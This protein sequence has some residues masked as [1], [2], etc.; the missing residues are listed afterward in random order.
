MVEKS[1][2]DIMVCPACKG[3]VIE[4]DSKI[5]CQDCG[6]KYPIRDTIPVMLIEEAE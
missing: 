3:G 2:L 5:I 6:K 1:L 4:K